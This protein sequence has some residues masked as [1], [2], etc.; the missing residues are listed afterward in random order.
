MKIYDFLIIGAGSAG[1]NSAAYLQKRGLKV[2]IA[3]KEGVA[4]GGS[5]AAG[6]FLSPLAGVENSYNLF[7]NR[8]LEYSLDF[9]ETMFQ[10]EIVKSGVLRVANENFDTAKLQTNSIKNRYISTKE[11]KEIS[12]NFAQIDG[13][14]YENA[15][16][17]NPHEVCR[18]LI[19]ECDFYKLHVEE[20]RYEDGFYL[21][22]DFM[23]KDVILAQGVIKPIVSTPYI[24]IAPIFG[25][26]IDVKTTT[27][28]PFNIH[29]SISVS[30]NKNDSTISIGAT[31]ERH[32]TSQIE[33]LTS[34][35]KCAFYTNSEQG[36][37][38][39]LLMEASELIKLEDLEVT[40]IYRGARATIKSY[41]PVIG[42]VIDYEESLKKYPSIK[43]GT[44]IMPELL[45]YFPNLYIINALGSRGFVVAPLLAK[46]LCEEILDSKKIPQELSSEK[47]FYKMARAKNQ[48][49]I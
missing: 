40:K 49:V 45:T 8:A 29:K 34:C 17:L 41:F 4:S 32:D 31:K 10:D 39:E 48:I 13:Y 15:A 44:K 9:Y 3:D 20:L 18:E 19:K 11:L 5:G 33:C 7:I 22:D 1:C 2:A 38:E 36:Q 14:F 6:A 12:Q 46:L 37:V 30:T 27:K 28:V 35:D 42:K 21:F 47:L 26:K 43:N 24:K 23:A 16:I 25:V